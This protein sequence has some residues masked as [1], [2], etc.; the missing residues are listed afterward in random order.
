MAQDSDVDGVWLFGS[1]GQ[2]EAGALDTDLAAEGVAVEFDFYGRLYFELPKRVDFVN[3]S[4]NPPVGAI[5]RVK[6]VRLYE[7]QS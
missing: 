4:Q 1:A 5:I 6:G 2:D 7:R 3:L